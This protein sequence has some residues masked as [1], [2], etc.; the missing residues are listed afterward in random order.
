MYFSLSTDVAVGANKDL[1]VE[2]DVVLSETV[3]EFLSENGHRVDTAYDVAEAEEKLYENRYDV[4]V[5]DVNL[6]DGDGFSLLAEARSSGLRTPVIF[7]TSR[8]RIEDLETGFASGGDDYLRKPFE[9]K[10]L[11]LRI[12]TLLKRNFYHESSEYIEIDESI[13]YD[14]TKD[15][16]LVQDKAVKLGKKEA[17]LLKLFMQHIGEIIDH[18]RIFEYVWDY[19]EEP[20]DAALR[21][22]IKNLRKIVGKEKIVSF[23]KQGYQFVTA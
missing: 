21:T 12:E 22:Y 10:E 11:L 1:C 2:D 17:R 3:E 16:L 18:E 19:D 6:P 5:M 14:I 23:K 8:D 13:R 4:V 9:L 7:L 20:S 15:K